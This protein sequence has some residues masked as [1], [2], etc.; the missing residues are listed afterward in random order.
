MDEQTKV[1]ETLTKESA[2]ENGKLDQLNGTIQE[3]KTAI[4]NLKEQLQTT[5]QE[6]Q[7]KQKAKDDIAEN[8]SKRDAMIAYHRKNHKTL[9]DAMA[10]YEVNVNF[11]EI[12]HTHF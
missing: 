8:S 3:Y 1:L 6:L 11:T 2:D 7:E 10:K 5:E 4:V 9:T 12:W